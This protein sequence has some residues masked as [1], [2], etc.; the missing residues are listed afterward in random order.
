VP[1]ALRVISGAGDGSVR[2][3]RVSDAVRERLLEAHPDAV[4]CVAAL[5]EARFVSASVDKTLRVWR[6]ADGGCDAV[7]RGHSD[8]VRACAGLPCGTRAV[9]AS[10]DKTLRVWD[11]DAGTCLRVLAGHTAAVWAVCVLDNGAI[12]SG[13]WD[14]VVRIWDVEYGRRVGRRCWS[15]L[16]LLPPVRPHAAVAGSC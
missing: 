4:R 15:H 3:T 13:G 14:H 8:T 1:N 10:D 11:A 16:V 12:A 9:S 2:V 6:L 5:G 7:L